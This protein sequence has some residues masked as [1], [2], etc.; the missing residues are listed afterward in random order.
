LYTDFRKA[1]DSVDHGILLNK[2]LDFGFHGSLFAWC[3]SYLR[4]REQQVVLNGC[5]SD[6][7]LATSGVPQ[8]SHLGPLF[9]NIF[10]NDF[11][12]FK[13]LTLRRRSKNL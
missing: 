7:F 13:K 5:Q 12:I 4:N 9:F 6:I 2:L 8:G 10:I 11:L 3:S 1:F